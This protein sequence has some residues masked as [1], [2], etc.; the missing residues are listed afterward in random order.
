MARYESSLQNMY[1]QTIFE[2]EEFFSES[3]MTRNILNWSRFNL[4]HEDYSISNEG[5][6]TPNSSGVT[7]YFIISVDIIHQIVIQKCR[8]PNQKS[9]IPKMSSR[10]WHVSFTC[11][12]LPDHRHL[13]VVYPN[14]NSS[15][16]IRSFLRI[17]PS[18]RFWKKEREKTV[19]E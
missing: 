11:S 8:K 9:V 3:V 15:V 16:Q 7:C 14:V 18:D 1:N 19:K 2:D 10:F 12:V 5:V 4:Q 13:N 17:S 6:L